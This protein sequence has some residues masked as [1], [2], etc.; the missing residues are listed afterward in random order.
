MVPL[1]GLVS[2]D[3]PKSLVRP[4]SMGSFRRI[5]QEHCHDPRYM[6][7]IARKKHLVRADSQVVMPDKRPGRD[8]AWPP[9]HGLVSPDCAH[10]PLRP[11]LH[12]VNCPKNDKSRTVQPVIRP[13]AS[14][15]RFPPGSGSPGR[16]GWPWAGAGRRRGSAGRRR[17]AARRCGSPGIS[18]V[19]PSSLRGIMGSRI[20]LEAV[21]PAGMIILSSAEVPQIA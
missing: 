17:S 13:P 20:E 11:P 18:D 6:G 21:E 10:L 1:H 14:S 15:W 3:S 4:R 8:D 2:P 9:V 5:V 19:A 7:L 12:G 16:R